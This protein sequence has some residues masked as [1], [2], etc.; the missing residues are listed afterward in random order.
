MEITKIVYRSSL[1]VFRG[2]SKAEKL[3]TLEDQVF[4]SDLSRGHVGPVSSHQQR[5]GA[6]AVSAQASWHTGG[7]PH[8][9][10]ESAAS[11][12]SSH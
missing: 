1:E 6:S 8:H 3:E 7:G 2:G 10:P 5:L 9:R 11:E 12:C 4:F